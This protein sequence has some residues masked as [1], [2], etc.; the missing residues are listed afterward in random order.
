MEYALSPAFAPLAPSTPG[1]HGLVI[2]DK[3]VIPGCMLLLGLSLSMQ[4]ASPFLC[5][6]F[7]ERQAL[8]DVIDTM[9]GKNRSEP[10]SSTIEA[11]RYLSSTTLGNGPFVGGD[12]MA[13][14]DGG[15]I[16]SGLTSW[17]NNFK[18]QTRS[19]PNLRV[20]LQ[21]AIGLSLNTI[22]SAAKI[23]ITW[24]AAVCVD[25]PLYCSEPRHHLDSTIMC[26]GL[27]L[28]LSF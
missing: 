15:G 14:T 4:R 2:P 10:T 20:P 12:I 6:P 9:L 23:D 11:A 24:M 7:R 1:V 28:P 19:A 3:S 17:A 18:V 16:E 13:T 26:A 27:E 22:S 21:D 8:R 25:D 5:L